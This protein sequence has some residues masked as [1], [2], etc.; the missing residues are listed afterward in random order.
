MRC[1]NC[2]RNKHHLMQNCTILLQRGFWTAATKNFGEN[3]I[4]VDGDLAE[5]IKRS[6]FD[7]LGD[8]VPHGSSPDFS[9]VGHL[10]SKHLSRNTLLM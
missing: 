8:S 7:Q 2:Y 4:N 1:S 5:S 6:G 10:A 3:K 9:R